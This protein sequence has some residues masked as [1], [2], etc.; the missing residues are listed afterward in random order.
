M[1]WM[2]GDFGL[3]PTGNVETLEGLPRKLIIS[4]LFCTH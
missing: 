4:E 2:I 3:H 1:A